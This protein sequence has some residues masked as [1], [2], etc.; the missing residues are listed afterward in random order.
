LCL[1]SCRSQIDVEY[2]KSTGWSYSD[3]YWVTDFFTFDTSGYYSI[4]GDTIFVHG[5]P[6]ALIVDLDKKSFDLTITSLDGKKTG[7][8]MDER[9][10]QH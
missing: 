2:I 7:H 9:E 5:K 8:Y 1:T 10:M 4:K 3:G 6:Q